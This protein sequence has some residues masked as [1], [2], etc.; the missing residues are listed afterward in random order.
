MGLKNVVVALTADHGV[1]PIPQQAAKLGVAAGRLDLDGMAAAL[2]VTL[3][4]RFS[5]GKE[6]QYLLPQQELPYLALDPRAFAGVKVTEEAAETAVAEA[7]PAAVRGLGAPEAAPSTAATPEGSR[8]YAE[9]RLDP[10]PQVAFLRTKVDLAA[11]KVPNTEFG[12]MIAHSFTAHGGWYVMVV[13]TPYQTEE[14]Q[15]IQTTHFS[16][17]SYDRHVP[18]GF[19]WGGV[20]AGVQAREGGAGGYRGDAG[21]GAAGECAVEQCGTGADG[22]DD[23]GGWAVAG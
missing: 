3:N 4:A 5:P 13:P 9:A 21:G 17:W 16:P 18:L 7:I 22:G 14:L 2:E 1:A 10:D 20:C 11:G 23:A 8:T 19:F 6:V 12:R 15:G